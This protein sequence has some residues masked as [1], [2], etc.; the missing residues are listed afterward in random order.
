MH[1]AAEFAKKYIFTWDILDTNR[2]TGV[3][4]KVV[5]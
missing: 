5:L 2:Q 1:G 3:D 4:K